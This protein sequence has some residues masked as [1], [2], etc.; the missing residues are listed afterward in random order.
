MSETST[1]T[2]PELLAL[3]EKLE[4]DAKPAPYTPPIRCDR[5]MNDYAIERQQRLAQGQ[6]VGGFTRT[7]G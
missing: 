4:A 6:Y 1:K 5:G 7:K 2:W 3:H